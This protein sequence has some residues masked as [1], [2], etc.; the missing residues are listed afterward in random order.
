MIN[1]TLTMIPGPSP[2]HTRILHALAQPTTSHVAP[3]F[4]EEFPGTVPRSRPT[5]RP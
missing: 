1:E 5:S 2:V 4:V 3:S